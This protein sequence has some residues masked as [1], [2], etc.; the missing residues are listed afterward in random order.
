MGTDAQLMH[1]PTRK[2]IYID[3]LHNIE[4]V[5]LELHELDNDLRHNG[6]S[7]AKLTSCVEDMSQFLFKHHSDRCLI[8]EDILK[9]LGQFED[10][11]MI[12]VLPDWNDDYYED[13]PDD[14]DAFISLC[15]SKTK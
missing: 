3:R 11:E 5:I 12:K 6:V 7:V 1:I 13:H 10:S 2:K 4:N 14:T 8:Y 15:K 9:W